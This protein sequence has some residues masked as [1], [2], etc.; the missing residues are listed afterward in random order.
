MPQNEQRQLIESEEEHDWINL[1][2]EVLLLEELEEA[3]TSLETHVQQFAAIEQ[4]PQNRGGI[5]KISI[6]TSSRMSDCSQYGNY[7]SVQMITQCGEWLRTLRNGAMPSG[8]ALDRTA[9]RCLI[10]HWLNHR[11]Q[12]QQNHLWGGSFNS[13]QQTGMPEWSSE[14]LKKKYRLVNKCL[15][16]PYGLGCRVC[17]SWQYLSTMSRPRKAQ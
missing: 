16:Q 6:S 8:R 17:L 14:I 1:L 3:R 4:Q 10:Y 15:P 5:W 12:F 9:S 2:A 13:I 11:H 7:V